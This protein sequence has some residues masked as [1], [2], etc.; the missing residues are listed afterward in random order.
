MMVWLGA[1]STGLGV[2]GC[3]AA[4]GG[5]DAAEA[6]RVDSH[7]D[8]LGSG[9]HGPCL[10]GACVD[11][12]ADLGDGHLMFKFHHQPGFDYFN[13]LWGIVDTPFV[14]EENR[15]GQYD[16]FGAK[17]G[18]LYQF[19]V[20]DC[21]SSP[22][23]WPSVCTGFTAPT[24]IYVQDAG[25]HWIDSDF[26]SQAQIDAAFVAST[27]L[28]GGFGGFE[29]PLRACSV[30]FN[31]GQHLGKFFDGACFIGW[32]GQEFALKG[33]MVLDHVADN[34]G[35]VWA[36]HGFNPGGAIAGGYENGIQQSV[37]LAFHENGFHPGKTIGDG[38]NVSWGGLEFHE[39][40]Y[41]VLARL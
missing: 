9:A 20:E 41:Q 36:H 7:R 35:W 27:E 19:H 15:S 12:L 22:W 34:V 39:T 33:S 37:C 6:N 3:G 26:A 40:D 16:V 29:R 17:I 24:F 28:A 11:S 14:Q 2:L 13:V 1:L 32:G 30:H 18:A 21:S 38:C 4:D 5:G 31:G 25:S 8:A 23:P 10:G